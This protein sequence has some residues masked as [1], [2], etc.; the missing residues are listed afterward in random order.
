MLNIVQDVQEYRSS[1]A[2]A[3]LLF[4]PHV[5]GQFNLLDFVFFAENGSGQ[6]DFLHRRQRSASNTA[7]MPMA[8]NTSTKDKR[9]RRM[10]VALP[11]VGCVTSC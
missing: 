4:I 6:A 7:T 8:T 10:A 2:L 5:Q 9:L 1:L 3:A 11:P